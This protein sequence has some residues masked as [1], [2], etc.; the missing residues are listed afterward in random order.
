M[1][2][3]LYKTTPSRVTLAEVELKDGHGNITR[4][5]EQ[6]AAYVYGFKPYYLHW[7]LNE[8]LE[9][10]YIDPAKRAWRNSG[11]R[12]PRLG[13]FEKVKPGSDVYLTGHH[14]SIL[15]DCLYD[16]RIGRVIRVIRSR[17]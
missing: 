12:P 9:K 4:S 6:V 16:R 14:I 13:T 15:D 17:I 11:T 7:E 8:K 2:S 3:Y 5:V 1:G 10:R